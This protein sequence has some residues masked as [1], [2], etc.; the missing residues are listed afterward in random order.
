MANAA[1]HIAATFGATPAPLYGVV[2]NAGVV[3]AD[4][5]TLLDVNVFGVRRVCEAVV[6]LLDPT[7]G[8]VVNITSAAGPNYVA[9]CD[10]ERKRFFLDAN[11]E[12]PALDAFMRQSIPSWPA[13]NSAYGLSKACANSYTMLLARNHPALRVNA[14]TPGFIETDSTRPWAEEQGKAPSEIGLKPPS[15]GTRSALFLL[16]GEPEGNGRYYGSDAKR[17]PLDRYRA[18][19]TEPYTGD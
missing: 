1:A 17:S 2:N 10:T 9:D 11:I 19:G 18:P 13:D 14:C 7:R 5:G 4:I 12:W 8:R 15:E 6:P 3:T 16:F